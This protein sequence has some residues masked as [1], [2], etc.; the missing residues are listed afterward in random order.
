M[1]HFFSLVF[2]EMRL[3][4]LRQQVNQAVIMRKQKVLSSRY[5]QFIREEF[6]ASYI[7]AALTAVATELQYKHQNIID[8]YIRYFNPTYCFKLL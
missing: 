6:H 3:C 2:K 8:Q 5:L 7:Y 1:P 4:F